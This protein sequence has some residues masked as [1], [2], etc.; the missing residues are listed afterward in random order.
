M[1][2]TTSDIRSVERTIEFDRNCC[3]RIAEVRTFDAKGI[4]SIFVVFYYSAIAGILLKPQET[5]RQKTAK[6]A[7]ADCFHVI[8][9]V[10]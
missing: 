9:D 4:A 6:R 5:L 8:S 2:H 7:L 10:V 1:G 3:V